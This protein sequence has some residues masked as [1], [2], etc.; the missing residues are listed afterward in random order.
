MATVVWMISSTG[1]R[2]MPQTASFMAQQVSSPVKKP[3]GKGTGP[4][5]HTDFGGN[6]VGR[7]SSRG[8]QDVFEQAV[9]AGWM[10]REKTIRII[11]P[12]AVPRDLKRGGASAHRQVRPAFHQTRFS[13]ASASGTG[14]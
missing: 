2:N 10:L 8:K 12:P 4:A 7:V 5:Q 13:A 9:R 14:F 6:P 3:P 1:N 11:R